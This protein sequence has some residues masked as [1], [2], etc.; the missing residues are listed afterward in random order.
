MRLVH[1][2]LAIAILSLAGGVAVHYYMSHSMEVRVRDNSE[3]LE[4]QGDEIKRTGDRVDDHEV[5]LRTVEETAARTTKQVTALESRLGELREKVTVLSK[6][7]E[8]N[9]ATI[10]ELRKEMAKVKMW[11]EELSARNEAYRGEID[12]LR[13]ELE[14][15]TRR[16]AELERRLRLIEDR[17]GIEPPRP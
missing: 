13:K 6:D 7:G 8:R 17:L 12:E 10:A 15:G 9:A 11:I 14:G 1:T 2:V 5:R 4:R 3:R 16:D